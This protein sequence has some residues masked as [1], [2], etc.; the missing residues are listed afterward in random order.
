MSL[1]NDALRKKRSEQF[2]TGDVPVPGWG[3]SGVM[4]SR[5]RQWIVASSGIALLVVTSAVWLY[6]CASPLA[7]GRAGAASPLRPGVPHVIEEKEPQSAEKASAAT[8]AVAPQ[9]AAAATTIAIAPAAPAIPASEARRAVDEIK[10][11]PVH[12]SSAADRDSSGTGADALRKQSDTAPDIDPRPSQEHPGSDPRAVVSHTTPVE[13]PRESD[14]LFQRACQFHRRHDL[15]QATALYQAVL[16]KDPGHTQAR[17]NLVAAYLQS[18]AYSQAYPI[19]AK[20]FSENPENQQIM[21]NLAISHIGCGRDREA[22][23][24]L[25]KAAK[26]P[27]APLFEITFHKAVALG[28][29]GRAKSALACYRSA[30]KMRPDDPELLFNMALSYDRGQQYSVAVDYYFKYL[31]HARKSDAHQ[32]LQIRRRIRTLQAYNVENKLKE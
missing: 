28:H 24:L 5:K 18:G 31:E 8:Q 10:S 27:D 23:A 16:K 3:K 2:S 9:T 4:S 20:L 21:L 11:P 25:E 6:L 1:L 29:L 17:L 13:P 14:S 15:V 22:L 30:E 19:V 32:I 26:R 7:S 12:Q